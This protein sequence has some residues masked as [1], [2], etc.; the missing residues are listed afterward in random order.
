MAE[1]TN[2]NVQTIAP[3]ES[4]IFTIATIP[5]T[6]GLV[7]WR[8]GSG[9]FNLSG[10]TFRRSTCC[11]N[12]NNAA[13]YDVRFG[14]NVAIPTGGTVAPISVSLALDGVTL[15]ETTSITTPTAVD[16]YDNLN[17]ISTIPIWNGC[18]STLTV[19]NTGTTPI[20]MQNAT[21]SFSR[22]D[23]VVHY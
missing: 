14:A 16:A 21:I 7:R 13:I 1:Y 20:N 23:S 8:A 3:G 17:W 9:A 18:C 11:C 19:R 10:R 4:A 5:C 2:P 12:R 15:P 22:P 6:A